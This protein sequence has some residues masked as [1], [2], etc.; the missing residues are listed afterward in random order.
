MSVS[1]GYKQGVSITTAKTLATAVGG[2]GIP[3]GSTIAVCQAEAQALRYRDDGTNPT[4]SVGMLLNVGDIVEFDKDLNALTF[5]EVAT[6]AKLNV[7]FY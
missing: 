5:I 1:K 6:G 2:G 4:A 7:T 3:N